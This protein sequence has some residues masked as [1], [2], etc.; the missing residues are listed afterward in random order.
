[1]TVYC[2]E[3]ECVELLAKLPHMSITKPKML[4]CG[5][6]IRCERCGKS[7]SE[8]DFNRLEKEGSK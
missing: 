5:N 2:P 4:K 6:L 7:M 1:M 3:Q 8:F